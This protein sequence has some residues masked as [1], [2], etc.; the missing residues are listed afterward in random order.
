MGE[1]TIFT[2]I[3]NKEIPADIVYE[4]DLV[5]AFRDINPQA[6]THILVVPREPLLN[7]SELTAETEHIAGRLLKVA[8]DI[9]RQEGLENGYR[10]ILNEGTDGGQDVPH[11]HMHLMAGRK[12]GWPPG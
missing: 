1:P 9:A 10:L 2:K 3:I 12:M 5:V 11:L 4:D 7:T 6:P 8:G